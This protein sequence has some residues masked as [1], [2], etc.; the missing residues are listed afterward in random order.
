MLLSRSQFKAY[1]NIV[2]TE[3]ERS[4]EG[5]VVFKDAM[6]LQISNNFSAANMQLIL[7]LGTKER[8]PKRDYRTTTPITIE[9]NMDKFLAGDFVDVYSYLFV[10]FLNDG[11]F[12][13]N[14]KIDFIEFSI[15]LME[16]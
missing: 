16:R 8:I 3:V 1:N 11:T 9:D 7:R 10:A 5:G 14:K 12:N 13:G 4:V 15:I 6:S 2:F